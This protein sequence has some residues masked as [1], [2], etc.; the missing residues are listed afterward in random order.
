M[1]LATFANSL[2]AGNQVLLEIKFVVVATLK[3][4]MR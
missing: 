4:L 1:A 3:P 2:L